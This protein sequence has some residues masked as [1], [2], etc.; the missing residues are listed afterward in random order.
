MNIVIGLS[1][2]ANWKGKNYNLVLVI[3]DRL[4]KMVYN[5]LVKVTMDALKLVEIIIDVVIQYHDLSNFI[6]NDRGAVFMSKF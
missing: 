2:S 3:V 5:E 4:T 1:L 6:I